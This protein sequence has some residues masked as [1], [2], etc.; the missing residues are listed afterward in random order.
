AIDAKRQGIGAVAL[1]GTVPLQDDGQ[2]LVGVN[3][4]AVAVVG[5]SA[6]DLSIVQGQGVVRGVIDRLAAAARDGVIRCRKNVYAV[7]HHAEGPQAFFGVSVFDHHLRAG[8]GVD[9][10]V[11]DDP[12]GSRSSKRRFIF[13]DSGNG[14]SAVDGQGAISSYAAK[15]ADFAVGGH[16]AAADGNVRV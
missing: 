7:H 6:A 14:G 2:V 10:T 9:I 13:R 4:A 12:L 5:V 8:A 16:R 15:R 11:D 3:A 1:D